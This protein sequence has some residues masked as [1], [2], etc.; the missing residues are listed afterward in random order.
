MDRDAAMQLLKDVSEPL[1]VMLE[2][3][4]PAD[5]SMLWVLRCAAE[6]AAV[7]PGLMC[8][9]KPRGGQRDLTDPQ[10]QWQVCLLCLQGSYMCPSAFPAS[11][12]SAA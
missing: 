8:R 1:A 7:W 2:P 6:L 11:P 9:A 4:R 3:G 5:Q 12:P 10:V